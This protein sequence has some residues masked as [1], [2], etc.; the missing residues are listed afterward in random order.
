MERGN[1]MPVA[2]KIPAGSKT[3]IELKFVPENPAELWSEYNTKVYELMAEVRNG[4]NTEAENGRESL[5]TVFGFRDLS[6]NKKFILN[7]KPIFLR[8][9]HDAMI[10]P[11]TGVFP[12]GFGFMAEG[13]MISKSYGINHYR[14]HTRCPPEAAF[15]SR[16][17]QHI[18]GPQLPFWGQF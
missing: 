8:G 12:T 9:K 6:T 5:R 17:C 11:K 2:V 15:C 7:G 16:S 14:Y 18:Y 13:F 3:C 1:K 10:F 4:E